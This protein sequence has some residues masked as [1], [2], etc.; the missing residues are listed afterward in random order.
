MA[1]DIGV[2]A[3]SQ[4]KTDG[5]S[6]WVAVGISV[7]DV[8]DSSRVGESNPN[9][10]A[11]VV[12]VWCC[13]ELLD[14]FRGCEGSAEDLSF[15]MCW[16]LWLESCPNPD[17]N[18]GLTRSVSWVLA[19]DTLQPRYHIG[20]CLHQLFIAWERH[21]RFFTSRLSKLMRNELIRKYLTAE[22]KSLYTS[23]LRA[24]SLELKYLLRTKHGG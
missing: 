1:D 14:I 12:K 23:T 2:L 15:G 21:V 18:G 17:Q 7:W 4:M 5:D 6:S 22:V 3:V 24:P 9:W 16:W 8:G 13:G 20:S 10:C 19:K 11:W